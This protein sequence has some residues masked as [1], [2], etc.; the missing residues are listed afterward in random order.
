MSCYWMDRV[1]RVGLLFFAELNLTNGPSL[2]LFFFVQML[3][4][5]MQS[6]RTAKVW[7]DIDLRDKLNYVSDLPGNVGNDSSLL[8]T[9]YF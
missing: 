6:H 9:R 7:C 4:V 5:S 8:L 1:F 3:V 2:M